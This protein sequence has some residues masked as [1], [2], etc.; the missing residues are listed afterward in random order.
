MCRPQPLWEANFSSTRSK[1][2]VTHVCVGCSNTMCQLP[3]IKLKTILS[4]I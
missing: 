1:G 2:H 3:F 4:I